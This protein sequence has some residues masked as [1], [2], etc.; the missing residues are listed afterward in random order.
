[1]TTIRHR[2]LALRAEL[3]EVLAE[4]D[5][6]APPPAP[7][8]IWMTVPQFAAARHLH[9]DTVRRYIRDGMPAMRAGKGW[10]IRVEA[11]DAWLAAGGALGSAARCGAKQGMH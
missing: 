1:V 11:A 10:R 6:P 8:S 3:D 2:L 7:V 9:P 5:A 4:L